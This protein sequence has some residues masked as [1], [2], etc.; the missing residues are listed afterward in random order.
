MVSITL[1]AAGIQ[2]SVLQLPLAINIPG[3]QADEATVA[4][5][6]AAIAIQFPKVCLSIC[7]F[8]SQTYRMTIGGQSSMR[9]AKKYR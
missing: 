2:P 1:S 5:V 8:S 6:K 9:H 7:E 4:D 3:K